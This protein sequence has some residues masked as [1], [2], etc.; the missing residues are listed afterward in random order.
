MNSTPIETERKFLIYMP[1]LETLCSQPEIRIQE[2]NQTYLLTDGKK[3]ARI[4]KI[5]ERG[6]ISYIKTVKERI[7]DLSCYE[8]EKEITED[9]YLELLKYA[10]EEKQSINKTRYSFKYGRHVIEIDIYSFWN[11]RAT[12]EIELSSEDEEFSIPEF[13]KVAKEVS[14][15][16]RYKNTNLAK[17]VPQDKI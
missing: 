1:C 9:C 10:D 5:T 4:R 6:K 7:S 14:T 3:N 11:D 13:I 16:K 17:N 8:E 2:I 15:D 12:L